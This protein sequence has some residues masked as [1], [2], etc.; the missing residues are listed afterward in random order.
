MT[1]KSFKK[2]KKN[3]EEKSKQSF[4][5]KIVKFLFGPFYYG[6]YDGEEETKK[7]SIYTRLAK[8]AFGQ[9]LYGE[10]PFSEKLIKFL[11]GPFYYGLYDGKEETK[12]LSI[13]TRLAKSA[14]GQMTYGL[15]ENYFNDMWNMI[16]LSTNVLIIATLIEQAKLLS[17]KMENTQHT[18]VLSSI[19]PPLLAAELMFYLSGLRRTGPLIRMIIKIIKGIDGVLIILALMVVSFAGSYTIQFQKKSPI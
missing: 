15:Y 6:L 4:F 17:N 2:E 11:F 1:V 9:M 16:H 7:L 19:I 14:F 13:Y 5:E 10:K 8:S 18:I 3:E 12:K